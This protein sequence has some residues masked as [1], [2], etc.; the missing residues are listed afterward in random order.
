[1]AIKASLTGR[2]RNTQLPRS[3]AL[4][5]LFEAV[6]NA[7]QTVDE[8]HDSMDST[9]IEIRITH[10]QQ[11]SMQ[12]GE[13]ELAH[14]EAIS[15]FTISDNGKG[16]DDGNMESFETLDSE[17]KADEGCR[18]VGR[19]LWLKAFKQVQV[20]SNYRDSDNVMRRREFTFTPT[21]GVNPQPIQDSDAQETGSEVHLVSFSEFYRQATPK[22]IHSIARN[23]L[24][25]C[26]W[27]FVR[28]GGAPN[29]AIVDDSGQVELNSLYDDY[30]LAYA[31]VEHITIK[32]QE[33]SFIHLRLRPTSRLHPQLNW[34]AANRVVDKENLIGMLPG[35]HGKL[36]DGDTEFI[37]SC[38]IMSSFLDTAVR[39]ERTGFSI[40]EDS[41]GTFDQE[42]PSMSDIRKAAVQ[43]AE[44]YLQANLTELREAGRARVERFV[45]SKAPRYRPIL[46]HIDDDKLSVNP[47]IADKDLELQLHRYLTDLEM[48]LLTE[49]QYILNLNNE[50]D[51]EYKERLKIYV[52]R[53]DDFKKSD[54]VAYVF[55]RRV[56]L[57][58]FAKAIEIDEYGK[59]SREDV[60][61][62]LIMPMRTTSD[63]EAHSVSNLWLIDEG[64]AFHNFLASDKTINSM[65]ITGST[66]NQEPDLLALQV[67]DNPILVSDGESFPLA[68]IVVVE[69]KRP[70]RNDA[71]PGLDKDPISQALNYLERVRGGGVMTAKGRPIPQSDHIPGFCYIIADL[72]PRMHERC[73]QSDLRPTPDHLGYFGY[74][75]NYRAYI[76]VYSFDRLLNLANQRNRAFFD[77][78]NLP[79]H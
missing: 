7:I 65:P 56:I 23:V 79:V 62:N 57:D 31:T 47:T 63:D 77:V 40:P 32:N 78:L 50:G 44:R 20:V 45:N 28:P 75:A 66:S 15:G 52:E 36:K 17:Y 55:R 67:Y 30:M 24:E 16:F 26:L 4:L 58:L 46:K 76:E 29:I 69:I 11:P 6:V 5:P 27:Y 59:Y 10:D 8:T 33:F 64:L 54:L 18:G 71:A 60:I 42:D 34:C 14:L 13:D 9:R 68:S 37:Y 12:F 25:H 70:M 35:L 21:Q 74:N 51:D 38:F 73:K 61:H 53:V 1:M 39:Q 48:E 2:L 19:L 3:H 49:G 41:E 22:N 43:A 72:T